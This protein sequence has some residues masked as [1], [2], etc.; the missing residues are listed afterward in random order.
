[1]VVNSLL[2]VQKLGCRTKKFESI[3][4]RTFLGR[5]KSFLKFMKNIHTPNITFS[6]IFLGTCH[7][8]IFK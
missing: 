4:I 8:N 7:N 3:Q 6:Y 2:I 5:K 1:M